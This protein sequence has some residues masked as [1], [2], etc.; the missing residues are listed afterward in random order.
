MSIAHKRRDRLYII[1]EI[2]AITNEE[3]VLQ[4]H[5][6]YRA[7]LSMTQTYQYI[8][9]LLERELLEKVDKSYK[10]TKKGIEYLEAYEHLASLI[11]KP[12]EV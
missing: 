3:P 7:N 8:S 6:M 12:T 5:I 4:T 2:L 10:T 9:F 11:R 1:A